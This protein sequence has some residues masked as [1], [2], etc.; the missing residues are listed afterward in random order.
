M[1]R[2]FLITHQTKENTVELSRAIISAFARVGMEVVTEDWL[3]S[4]LDKR[5]NGLAEDRSAPFEA[6][7]A[8]GGDGTLLRANQFALLNDV[9]LLGVNNGRL[10][11]LTELEPEQIEAA[12]ARLLADDYEIDT[13][14]ML[15]IA[16][17]D[18][19]P[20]T[21]LNDAVISRGGYARLI[22]VKA[23]V[24]GDLV[25]RY[26]ADGLIVSTPTGSTGYSLSAGGPIVCPEVDCLIISPICAHS[27]Q[28]RPVIAAPSKEIVIELDCQ[29]AQEALLS[30][31]GTM[32]GTLKQRERVTVTCAEQRARF[33]RLYPRA[34]FSLIRNKLS[35]WSC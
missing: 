10:G 24:D 21:A 5:L 13:R 9:P 29:P 27:L 26:I 33:I 30:V 22:A 20:Y 19:A 14:M 31:D 15:S 17:E 7:V 3:F 32:I 25:G 8:V 16:R 34:F 35:E 4:R 12:C 6:V 2:I 28:H 11:F 23:F 1:K 18:S